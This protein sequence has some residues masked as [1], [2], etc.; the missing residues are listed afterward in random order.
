[1]LMI[2]S[3]NISM[4]DIINLLKL[5]QYLKNKIILNFLEIYYKLNDV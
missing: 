3:L 2:I 4:V 5:N 1:M